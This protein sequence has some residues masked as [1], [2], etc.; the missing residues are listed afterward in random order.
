MFEARKTEMEFFKKIEV[1]RK[2]PMS[3]GGKIIYRGNANCR[4]RLVARKIQKEKCQDLFSATPPLQTSK[5][6]VADCA[7]GQRQAK[8]LRIGIFDVSRAYFYA[9]VMRPLSSKNR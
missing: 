1:Y 6:L 2:V 8:Y 9:P 7:K 4:S 3:E 5:L